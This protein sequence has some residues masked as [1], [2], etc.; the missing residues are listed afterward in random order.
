MEGG[1]APRLWCK[2]IENKL[3]NHIFLCLNIISHTIIIAAMSNCSIIHILNIIFID[4][5][6]KIMFI[7]LCITYRI[8]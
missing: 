6:H 7:V 8:K 5:Y 2:R 3:I 1:D 4:K